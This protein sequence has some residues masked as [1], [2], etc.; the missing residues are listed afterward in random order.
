MPAG[1]GRMRSG[2]GRRR[3]RVMSF[4]QPCLL[5]MLTRDEG[6]GYSLH[7]ALTEFGFNPDRFD[8]SLI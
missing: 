1:R 8:P 7:G 6:H 4:L 3:Q 2:G 5:L